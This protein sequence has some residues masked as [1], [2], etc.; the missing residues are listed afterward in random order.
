MI[1]DF[2]QQRERRRVELRL[3]ELDIERR[4]LESARQALDVAAANGNPSQ[5]SVTQ[6][7]DGHE[8]ILLFRSLFRGRTDVYP[9]RWENRS[10][11]KSGYA[12]ACANEWV[13]GVC[14]KPRIKCGNCPKQAFIAVSDRIVERHLRGDIVAGIYPLMAGNTC[15]FVAIDFDGEGW[16]EDSRAFRHACDQHQVPVA[17]ERSR[18]GAGAHAWIFFAQAIMASQARQLATGLMSAAMERRPDIGFGSYDRLFPSQD[19]MPDGGFGNLIALPLQRVARDRGHSVFID[20]ELNPFI[21]QWEYLASLK[22]IEVS[23]VERLLT[24]LS[25]RRH[26]TTGIPLP[27]SDETSPTPW[28]LPQTPN[29]ESRVTEPLPKRVHVTLA[30]QVYIDR[31]GLPATMVT[32]LMRLAAFQNPEFYQAQALRL[33]TF[34]KPRVISRAELHS[35]H[36][37]LPRGCVDEVREAFTTH[38]VQIDVNDERCSGEPLVAQFMGTLRPEQQR[39][40]EALLEHD[41]GVLAATTAFGK[42]VLAISLIAARGCNV[43]ILVH[44]QQLLDQWVEQL[45]AF[46]DVEPDTIGTM[47]GGKKRL[48]GKI[49]VAMIQSLM[50]NHDVDERVMN[51][52]HLIVDECHHGSAVSFEAVIKRARGRYVLGLSATVARKDGHQPIVFMQCGPVRHRVTARAQLAARGGVHRAE[53]RETGF[54]AGELME[55]RVPI[56]AVYKALA[57]SEPRNARIFDDVLTALEMRRRP[58]V[59]TERRD[60]LELLASRFAPFVSKVIVLRGGMSARELGTALTTLRSDEPGERLVLAT[61]RYLGE[62]FDYAPLDTLFLTLPISWKGTLAQY[63]GRL[64]RE[65][66]DKRDVLVVDYSDL[67]VPMLARMAAKRVAGYRN[68]GYMVEHIGVGDRRERGPATTVVPTPG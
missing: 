47:G 67:G 45:R 57:E 40:V 15:Y 66:A 22:R 6:Q 52:G 11:G 42:T 34:D 51:Y 41:Y 23:V 7:A 16:I 14:E 62:G 5:S 53:M 30:D 48:T 13:R 18:S 38:G 46:L 12:P 49:D 24:V 17:I 29:P 56:A 10:S 27:V 61:G 19:L 63:V 64:H 60:H 31:T 3:A 39:A 55:S 59:L 9:A 21:D 33:P 58:L 26:G 37:A 43:L 2:T 50:R 36:I 35:H 65:H 25:S 44:R 32:R 54:T 20:D 4:A 68:L 28:A 8:K 1:T